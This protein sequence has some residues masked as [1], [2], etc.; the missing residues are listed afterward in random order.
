MKVQVRRRVDEARDVVALELGA[1][2]GELL[3]PFSAGAHIDV[4][5][6]SNLTRQYSLCNSPADRTRYLI[7]VLLDPASRGGSKAMHAVREGEI[8]EISEP[9]NHFPLHP[10]AHSVLL[11]GGIGITP[12]LCMAEQLA[13][14][15]A[16]F[17]LHYCVRSDDRLAFRDRLAQSDFSG[18][19]HT[20]V[21]ALP[22]GPHF[23][24]QTVLANPLPEKHVYVCGPGG[25]IDAVVQTA[26]ALNWAEGCVHRE[27]FAGTEPVKEGERPFQVR[28]ASSGQCIPVHPTQSIA[29]ALMAH[30]IDVPLSCEQGVCGT[31]LTRVLKGEP[32]HRDLY[33][34][35]AEREAHDQILVCCSRSRSAELIL[36]I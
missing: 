8:L 29:Q 1:V 10:A 6:P 33:L 14:V 23:D 19:V 2:Q 26:A 18:R 20:Y 34:S 4:R 28:L 27:Y 9:R 36:D 32:D 21:D 22:G 13:H 15:G 17:E 30:G 7:G 3:P 12:I 25:F 16:S 31:C 24:L 35:R 5:L 11:A